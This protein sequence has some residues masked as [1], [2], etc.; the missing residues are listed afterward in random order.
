MGSTT[1]RI[2]FAPWNHELIDSLSQEAKRY[3]D[4]HT[5]I[6]PW[7]NVAPGQALVCKSVI[8]APDRKVLFLLIF[9]PG[10]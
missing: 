4:A 6:I 2:F 5:L 9:I 8:I 3:D 7:K 1:N 10:R